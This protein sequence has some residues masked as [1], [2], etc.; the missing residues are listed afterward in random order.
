MKNLNLENFGVRELDAKEIVN[1]DGGGW[2]EDF[3]IWLG[4]KLGNTE[5]IL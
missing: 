3:L 5:K 1:I 2:Q 4:E